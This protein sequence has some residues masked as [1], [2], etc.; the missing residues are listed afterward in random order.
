MPLIEDQLV[1]GVSHVVEF[2]RK[3]EYRYLYNRHMQANI[4]PPERSDKAS[5][6]L[7]RKNSRSSLNGH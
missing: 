7:T 1:L 5:K 2:I 6:K 4:P 3:E